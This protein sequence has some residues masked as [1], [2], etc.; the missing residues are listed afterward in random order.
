MKLHP[1]IAGT[2][3]VWRKCRIRCPPRPH[4]RCL[5]MIKPLVTGFYYAFYFID[6]IHFFH[7]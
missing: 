2:K 3:P 5:T 1:E 6:C 4:L 7:T